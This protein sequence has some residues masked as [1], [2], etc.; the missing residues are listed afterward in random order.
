MNDFS[1]TPMTHS[2]GEFGYQIV[3]ITEQKM[4]RACCERGNSLS[5]VTMLVVLTIATP[6]ICNANWP[7][8]S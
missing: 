4:T 8:F 7:N 3:L 6:L 1:G 2:D 5:P